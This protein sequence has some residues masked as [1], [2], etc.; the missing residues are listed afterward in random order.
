VDLILANFI[1]LNFNIH[2]LLILGDVSTGHFDIHPSYGCL[3]PVMLICN[4]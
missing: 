1:N 2:I 4:P 3:C